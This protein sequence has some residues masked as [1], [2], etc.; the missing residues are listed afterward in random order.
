[1]KKNFIIVATIIDWHIFVLF[2]K[3]DPNVG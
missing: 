3:R 2:S 1:V